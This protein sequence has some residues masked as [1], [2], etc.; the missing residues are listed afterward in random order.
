M[1]FKD[2]YKIL[3]VT[4]NATQDEIKKVYRKLAVK[5]HPDK[6]AG[7]KGAEEK[8]KAISEAYSVLSDVEKRKKYDELGVN[9]NQ[10]QQQGN[11]REDF[12]WSQWA[13]QGGGNQRTRSTHGDQGFDESSFSDFFEELF[14]NKQGAGQRTRSARAAKGGDYKAEFTITLEEAYTGVSKEF[15]V[16]HKKIRIKLKPGTKDGQV[17]KLK[18]YGSPG[19]NGGASGDLYIHIIIPEHPVFKR[20]ENDLYADINVDLY[21]MLLGEKITIQ[22]LKGN[23]RM[24]MPKD[25]ENGKVLRLKGMGMPVYD[26]EKMFGDLYAKVNVVLPKNLTAKEIELIEQLAKMRS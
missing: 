23:I 15:E 14:G 7:N 18:G 1:D 22:T 21:S 8:F 9:Y 16:N 12:D 20:K 13:N 2:Y 25:T 24:D 10:Y 11:A 5:H 4:K 6:N 19:A 17:I 3:G 26:K